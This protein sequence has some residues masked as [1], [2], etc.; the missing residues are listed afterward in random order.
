MTFS[1]F[2]DDFFENDRPFGWDD[3]TEDEQD[4]LDAAYR[5]GTLDSHPS[6]SAADRNPSLC[7]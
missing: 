6:L 7:R 2:D 5:N 3:L 1:D 4:E